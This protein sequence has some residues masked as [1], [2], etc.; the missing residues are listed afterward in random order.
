MEKN[1]SKYRP[2]LLQAG[3][4]TTKTAGIKRIKPSCS[5][6]DYSCSPSKVRQ[7]TSVWAAQHSGSV[8]TLHPAALGLIIS[9]PEDFFCMF[10]SCFF[11]AGD[12]LVGHLSRRPG[13]D[14]GD[15]YEGPGSRQTEPGL[16]GS[17]VV[18]SRQREICSFCCLSFTHADLNCEV[19]STLTNTHE[20]I[21]FDFTSDYK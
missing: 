3:N 6:I 16:P 20:L 17:E 18:D 2:Q 1:E 7:S 4:S 19:L 10:P 15:L 13:Q 21:E 14:A 11:I 9:I 12:G 8:C 5:V